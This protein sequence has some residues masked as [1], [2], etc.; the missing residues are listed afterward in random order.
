MLLQRT[1]VPTWLPDSIQRDLSHTHAFAVQHN[2]GSIFNHLQLN[3]Y[4]TNHIVGLLHV[5]LQ[6]QAVQGG[7]HSCKQLSCYQIVEV[8]P[9]NI[10]REEGEGDW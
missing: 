10:V 4:V 9:N 8:Q 6:L 2:A 5:G 7:L 1:Q 3:V